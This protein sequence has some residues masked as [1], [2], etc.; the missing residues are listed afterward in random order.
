MSQLSG[1]QY[2]DPPEGGQQ[3]PA[4]PSWGTKQVEG[5][6]AT[7]LPKTSCLFQARGNLMPS[8]LFSLTNSSPLQ[9]SAQEVELIFLDSRSLKP[10]FHPGADVKT[11][12][13]TANRCT[14]QSCLGSK[15]YWCHRDIGHVFSLHPTPYH[16]PPL[17][18][19]IVSAQSPR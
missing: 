2:T 13:L 15:S 9:I 8:K 16:P 7:G 3:K 4:I 5:L 19:T 6:Q 11:K 17:S 14:S 1:I 10:K 12:G 18:S